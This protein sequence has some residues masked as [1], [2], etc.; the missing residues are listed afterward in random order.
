MV[1]IPDIKMLYQSDKVSRI[2]TRSH[3][4]RLFS[5]M[6]WGI[7]LFNA[8]ALA[9]LAGSLIYAKNYQNVLLSREAYMLQGQAETYA[10]TLV[11]NAITI[12]NSQAKNPVVTLNKEKAALMILRFAEKRHYR[13]ILFDDKNTVLAD[14]NDLIEY[15]TGLDE[16]TKRNYLMSFSSKEHGYIKNI[17]RM[18]A[19]QKPA[20]SW[21]S[22][23]D[24]AFHI[25]AGFPVVHSGRYVGAI[26]VS[27]RADFMNS[28]SRAMQIEIIIIFFGTL[29]FT[30]ILSIYFSRQLAKPLRQL[31]DYA[32]KV[33]QNV[34]IDAR[35]PDFSARDDEIGDLS[36]V[37]GEMT[38]SLRV[39]MESIEQFAADVSHE[40]KNP[41][42]SIR[43]A[44]ETLPKVTDKRKQAQLQEI[45]QQDIWRMDRLITDISRA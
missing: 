16:R 42:T 17:L 9:I 4:D 3:K 35:P 43:S 7:M 30:I 19:Q 34:A 15:K 38:E 22:V 24:G 39:R 26:L 8:F 23:V 2:K 12:N 29:C 31:A 6:T 11:E 28:V 36:L 27:A 10:E 45:I 33:R 18:A 44:V 41:L 5:S 32:D 21:T 37:L 40:L 25:Y 1:S 20:S 14:S 13:I